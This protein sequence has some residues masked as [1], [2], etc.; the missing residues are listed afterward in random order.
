MLG[1]PETLAQFLKQFRKKSELSQSF[2][3]K[4]TFYDETKHVS[5]IRAFLN[6]KEKMLKST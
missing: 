6:Q 1:K 3:N 5:V 2:R 4:A